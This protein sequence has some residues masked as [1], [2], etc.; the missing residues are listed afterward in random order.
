MPNISWLIRRLKAMSIPE[1]AWRLSQKSIEKQERA[2]FKGQKRQV[3]SAL[4]NPALSGLTP[5]ESKLRLNYGNA[6]FSLNT[7]V[8]LLSG[9]D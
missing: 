3:I 5:D 8:H 7:A 2:A 6:G 4:F 1:V 9:A